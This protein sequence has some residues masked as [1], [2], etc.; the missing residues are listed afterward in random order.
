MV[1]AS[2]SEIS[3]RRVQERKPTARHET[4]PKEANEPRKQEVSDLKV[5]SRFGVDQNGIAESAMDSSD[6]NGAADED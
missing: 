3:K 4:S 1:Q 6:V 2:N 5:G